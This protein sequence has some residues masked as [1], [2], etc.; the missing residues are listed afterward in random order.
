MSHFIFTDCDLDGAGSYM[1]YKWL[2]P[3]E[4]ISY[5][6]TRV[7]DLY[8]HVKA[9]ADRGDFDKYDQVLFFDFDVSDKKIHELIDR[10]NVTI[11][12]HHESN[13][14]DTDVIY[15]SAKC[16]IEE[17]TS[18]CKLVYKNYNGANKLSPTQ[19]LFVYLVDD[20][21][22]YTLNR[23]ESKQLNDVFWSYKGDR[24]AKLYRD[25]NADGF[26][27]FNTYHNNMLIIKQKDI[28]DIKSKAE[29]YIGEIDTGKNAYTVSS[30]MCDRHI[31]DIA[32][33][34][35]DKTGTDA[36]MVVNPK[37][38]KVSFRKRNDSCTLSMVKL[39]SV[40]TDESGGHESAAGGLICDKFLNFTKK[41]VPYHG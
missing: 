24:L 26:T 39:A 4:D 9:F 6:V 32:D 40:L 16:I 28:A 18:T 31:N 25:F 37:T 23:V 10:E 11:I 12:D 29:I 8:Q 5:T 34:V 14:D 3:E 19:K 13:I 7:N 1:T 21:D 38:S 2:N 27:G 17:S 33:Y 41:L 36:A 20:Y 30:I 35:L 15:R 22:S